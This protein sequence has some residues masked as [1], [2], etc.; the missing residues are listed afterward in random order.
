MKKTI[1]ACLFSAILAAQATAQIGER[2]ALETH[3]DQ[4]DI[5]SG[6]VTIQDCFDQGRVIFNA[7]FNVLDG[8]GRP[9][10]RGNGQ[11]RN[12]DE[13]D[14]TRVSSPEANS[15]A[16]CHNQPSA[17]GGGDFVANVF[18]GAEGLDPVTESVSSLI[19]NERNTL[20]MFGAGPLEMLARE[21]TT[22]LHA[23]RDAAIAEAQSSGSP[24]TSALTAKGV[25]FGS[26]TAM[27]DGRIDPTN[28][29]GVDWDL[30]IKPFHQ[31]G[32]LVSLRQFTNNAMNRHHG[33]Q[34]VERFGLG[35]DLDGDGFTNEITIGDITAASLFQA[36]LGTPTIVIP[37]D[38][39]REAAGRRGKGLFNAIGC[40]TC[41]I[42]SMIL[43]DRNFTEPGP[44]NPP[45]NLTPEQ[46]SQ[47]AS[48][49]MTVEGFEPRLRPVSG[50]R[51]RIFAYTDLK[52]HNLNDAELDHFAN[53]QVSQG[54]LLGFASADEFTIGSQPR[55]TEEFLTRKLWDAG[56]SGPYGHRGDLTTLT[57]A[58][59]FHG[60]EARDSR[61]AFFGLSQ[62]DQDA[63]VEFLKAM[64]AL[65]DTTGGV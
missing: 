41:H 47:L 28:I 46:V 45:G 49:D 43:D 27:P 60:G 55:P 26:L 8:Q 21:M 31:K 9:A 1:G 24:V 6:V 5:E 13:P 62:D 12:P 33:M 51:A 44:F 18:V 53:E 29:E 4:A 25:S 15:C 17:G 2:P 58:I 7:R 52:R 10:T 57:E 23:I 11:Q 14:F 16:G 54:N 22:E 37:D 39:A 32:A 50:G 34:S 48:F 38:P 64:Q 61:D 20:G 19:S 36:A 56:N 3:L 63:I 35:T 65:P 59:F 40:N 42:P 30:I